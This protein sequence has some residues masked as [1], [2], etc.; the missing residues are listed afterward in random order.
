MVSLTSLLLLAASAFAYN[1]PSNYGSNA[2]A[3][4]AFSGDPFKNYTLSA[5]GI[6]ASFI[7]YG[8]RITNLFVKDKNGCFQDVVLGYDNGTRK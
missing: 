5:E 8:A 6:S 7:P 3:F 2:S 4:P 1:T